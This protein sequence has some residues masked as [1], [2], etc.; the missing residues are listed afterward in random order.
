[1][2]DKVNN[3]IKQRPSVVAIVFGSVVS[4]MLLAAGVILQ[5]TVG[6]VIDQGKTIEVHRSNI[7]DI[8]K[9]VDR[10]ET[11]ALLWASTPGKLEAIAA[12]LDSIKEGQQ[13]VES[14]V[15]DHSRN[16]RP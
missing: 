5:G 10:L 9:R 1:M 6:T 16:D 14:A 7:I 4:A 13:R 15:A 3:H 12:R 2:C 8:G 11:A